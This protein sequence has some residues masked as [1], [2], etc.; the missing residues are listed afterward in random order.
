M[1]DKG[2]SKKVLGLSVQL[3]VGIVFGQP[4]SP[5]WSMQS[6]GKIFAM[7]ALR[8]GDPISPYLF[9]QVVDILN[10]SMY[11]G[12][13]KRVVKGFLVCSNRVQLSHLQ[14]VDDTLFFF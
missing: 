4:T 8:S 10:M 2:L 14:F 5:S 12:V 7:R 3:E 1:L 11:N 13:E 6:R 9:N